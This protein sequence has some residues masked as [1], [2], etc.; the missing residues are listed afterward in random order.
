VVVVPPLVPSLVP[1]VP[2]ISPPSEPDSCSPCSLENGFSHAETLTPR[3]STI[4]ATVTRPCAVQTIAG[5]R[6]RI[7]CAPVHA[8]TPGLR[9]QPTFYS[10]YEWSRILLDLNEYGQYGAERAR[11]GT[12]RNLDRPPVRAAQC[13]RE[14]YSVRRKVRSSRA[15]RRLDSGSPDR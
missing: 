8:I 10:E 4:S 9:E 7:S 12:S 6:Y 11:R 13:P 15:R 1:V 5:V 14:T 3:P 2:E